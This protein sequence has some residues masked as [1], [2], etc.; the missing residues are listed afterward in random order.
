MAT[1]KVSEPKP[2]K[3]MGRPTIYTEELAERILDL[4]ATNTCGLPALCEKYPELPNQDTINEWRWKKSEFSDRYARAKM[5][6]AELMAEELNEI[7]SK[8]SFY[9][10]AEGN[11]RVDTGFTAAQRLIADTVKWQAAKLAPKI[12]GDRTQT[13][14]TVTIKHE[15]ALK[16][17]E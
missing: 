14:T 16:L 8:R 7:T 17:L 9:I 6:Q 2:K 15:D 4:V 5:F 1:K 10:D 11:Q 13:E 12:Y 3:K